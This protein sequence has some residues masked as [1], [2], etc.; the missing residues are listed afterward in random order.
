M[1]KD[2]LHSLLHLFFPHQCAGCGNDIIDDQQ[3]LCLQCIEQLPVTGFHRHANNPV[4][5]IFDGRLPLHNAAAYM[6]FAKNSL[7]QQ[8]IH[9]FKYKGNKEIGEYF[10][11][12]MGESIMQCNRFKK[13][14]ALVPL[15]LYISRERKR[16]Y[17]QAAILCRGI[18]ETIK[19][20]VLNNVV[21]RNKATQTQTRKDRVQRWQN[22][23]GMFGVADAAAIQN[24][25]ILLVDDVV[26]TG[27][28]LE[29][30]GQALLSAGPAFLSIYTMAYS[31]K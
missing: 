20:P 13:I 31:L 10:G 16:G 12:R 27:A 2:A 23:E 3:L 21:I 11:R 29:A 7:L 4:E 25:H 9:Q 19:V 30:C 5:K 8:L 24:K 26:T 18:A 15:P 22:M 17:N 14:D 1:I 6:Y 28:T